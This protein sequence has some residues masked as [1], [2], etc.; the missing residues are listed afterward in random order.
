MEGNDYIKIIVKELD[1]VMLT[2]NAILSS[3]IN[4]ESD[5]VFCSFYER[6]SSGIYYSIEIQ[7]SDEFKKTFIE[8]S[9]NF[10]FE[11][12]SSI[13]VI[14]NDEILKP[15]NYHHEISDDP[16]RVLLS[17][18]FNCK[19]TNKMTLDFSGI[20]NQV[21]SVEINLKEVNKPKLLVSCSN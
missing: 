18:A 5:S 12:E 21:N 1:P 16:N 4:Q 10:D 17:V 19:K 9:G 20:F 11:F 8:K 15:I 6:Y 2:Y 14:S 13:N 3:N 7:P